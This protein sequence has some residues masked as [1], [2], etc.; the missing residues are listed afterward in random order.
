MTVVLGSL[1]L[2][3]LASKPFPQFSTVVA[4]FAQ[5]M[6]IQTLAGF[7]GRYWIEVIHPGP[8]R[9]RVQIVLSVIGDHTRNIGISS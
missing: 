1:K 2:T 3:F 5:R 6:M 9:I 7:T 8:G 4:A